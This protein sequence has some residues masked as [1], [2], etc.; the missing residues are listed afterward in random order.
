[1]RIARAIGL[2][3][4]GALL[5]AGLLALLTVGPALL[6]LAGLLLVGLWWH[7]VFEADVSMVLAGAAV[8][9]LVLGVLSLPYEPCHPGETLSYPPLPG[10]RSSCGGTNPALYFVPAFLAFVGAATSALVAFRARN[11]GSA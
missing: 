11:P 1:M 4:A 3:L 10:Q 9:F 7:G 6:L 5:A 2:G 8:C